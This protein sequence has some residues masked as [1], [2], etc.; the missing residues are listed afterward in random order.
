MP[1]PP[2]ISKVWVDGTKE[3]ESV[4]IDLT[5]LSTSSTAPS[6]TVKSF[7]SNEATPLFVVVANS[8]SIVTVPAVSS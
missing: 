3:P 6:V 2:R 4:V 1:S 5:T 8:A 7:T